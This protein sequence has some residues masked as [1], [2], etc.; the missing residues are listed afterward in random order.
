MKWVIMVWTGSF[1]NLTIKQWSRKIDKKGHMRVEE[2]KVDEIN[3]DDRHYDGQDKNLWITSRENYGTVVEQLQRIIEV[4]HTRVCINSEITC[5][6]GY[7]GRSPPQMVKIQ[8][9]SKNF[10]LARNYHSQSQINQ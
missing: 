3:D 8:I 9:Q 5:A 4:I 6:I 1:M 2:E 7:L 10:W